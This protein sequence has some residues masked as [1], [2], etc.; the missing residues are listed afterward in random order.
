MKIVTL[1]YLI[2]NLGWANLANETQAIFRRLNGLVETF[3]VDAPKDGKQYGRQDGDWTE[4]EDS[5]GEVSDSRPYKSYT[6]LLTQIGSENPTAAVLENTLGFDVIWTRTGAGVYQTQNLVAATNKVFY[7]LKNSVTESRE[8]SISY[9][10]S[11][12]TVQTFSIS[13]SHIVTS[14]DDKL[15]NTPIEIR[16]Y[17]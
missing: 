3:I 13:A 17:E 4:I 7:Y 9:S 16:I 14:S 10:L 6:A 2:D 8:T 15:S 12:I 1:K 5:D 11:K